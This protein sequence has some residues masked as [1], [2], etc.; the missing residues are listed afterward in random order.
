MRAFRRTAAPT[1]PQAV[2]RT[3][4]ETDVW[5]TPNPKTRQTTWRYETS[6]DITV[7]QSDQRRSPG[8]LSRQG[9]PT[10]RW[11][12]YEAAVIA[13]RA[14]SPDHDYYLQ[15]KARLGVKR[16]GLS[17]ARRRLR[18]IHHQLATAGDIALAEAA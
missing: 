16:G 14:G 12:L 5:P 13:S 2:A 1:T 17:V 3:A 8:H 11:A 15:T 9:P 18:R 6:V 7:Y 4:D 10:L